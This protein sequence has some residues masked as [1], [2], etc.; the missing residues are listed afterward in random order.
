[1]SPTPIRKSWYEAIHSQTKRLTSV[2]DQM[3]DVSNIQAGVISVDTSPVSLETIVDRI[4]DGYSS[5]SPTYR[6]VAEPHQGLPDVVGDAARLHQILVNLIDNAV[7]FSP[8]G[9]TIL[10]SLSHDRSEGTVVVSVAD[11]GI[12]MSPADQKRLF[13]PFERGDRAETDC[14]AGP[15]LGL[16]VVRSLVDLMGGYIRVQSEDSVGTTV[17]IGIPVAKPPAESELRDVG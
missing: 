5:E 14:I 15:G 4:L 10:L 1:M 7:K 2:I 11:E 12:G 13:E 9:G 17:A 16:Y 3:L 8:N 6:F